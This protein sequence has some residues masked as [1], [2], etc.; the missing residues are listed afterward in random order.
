MA[1]LALKKTKT[2]AKKGPERGGQFDMSPD[3]KD[4]RPRPLNEVPSR[5]TSLA[6]STKKTLNIQSTIFQ[7]FLGK[8]DAHINCL[9]EQIFT[10]YRN[11]FE[12]DVKPVFRN[13]KNLFMK[14]FKDLEKQIQFKISST[15]KNVTL[16]KQFLTPYDAFKGN[17]SIGLT[18]VNDRKDLLSQNFSSVLS[19]SKPDQEPPNLMLDFT[20]SHIENLKNGYDFEEMGK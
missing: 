16:L 1:I 17:K 7:N 5:T 12:K 9:T 10:Q 18:S 6:K 11:L 19:I 15:L 13:K 14:Y 20:K 4:R 8:I 2:T 3:F